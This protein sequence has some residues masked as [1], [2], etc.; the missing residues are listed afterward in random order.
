M[1]K[2]QEVYRWITLN[3]AIMHVI[4]SVIINNKMYNYNDIITNL[5]CQERQA[6]NCVL[7]VTHESIWR[8]LLKLHVYH[9]NALH[10]HTHTHHVYSLKACVKDFIVYIN[11][12]ALLLLS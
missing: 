4:R 9:I 6:E 7:I 2:K 1:L 3:N 12:N 10:T 8:I 11:I 5:V